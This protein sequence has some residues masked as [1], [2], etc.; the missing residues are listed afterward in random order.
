MN[1]ILIELI[2]NRAGIEKVCIFLGGC[3]ARF[4]NKYILSN[5]YNMEKRFELK[6]Q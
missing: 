1:Q 4:K 2:K 6:L 5:L 3:A